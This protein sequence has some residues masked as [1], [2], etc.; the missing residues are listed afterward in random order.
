MSYVIYRIYI[1]PMTS[2]DLKIV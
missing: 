2:S 1:L